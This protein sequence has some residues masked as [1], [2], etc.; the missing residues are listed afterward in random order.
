MRAVRLPEAHAHL[1]GVGRPHVGVDTH[2]ADDFAC[3]AADVDV[4]ALVAAL[5]ETFDD[6]RFPA[7]RRE[8]MSECG[9][10]DA[11]A[12]DDGVGSQVSCEIRAL[13]VVM[14]SSM[15]STTSVGASTWAKWPTS[16]STSRRQSGRAS[17]AAYA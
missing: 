12:G 14:K 17:S 5:R 15:R 9:S 11:C 6:G 13:V 2:P 10:A 4:L 16:G 7:A 3:G 1:P 8:L